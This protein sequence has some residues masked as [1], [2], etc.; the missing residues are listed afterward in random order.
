MRRAVRREKA[1]RGAITERDPRYAPTVGS[2][3][4]VEAD[5]VTRDRWSMALSHAGHSAIVVASLR[6]AL[7]AVGEGGIDVVV[8]DAHDSITGLVELAR[9]IDALPDAPP[10]VLVS[11]SPAAPEASVRM[12]AA[13][14]LPKPCEPSE[15]VAV[16]TRLL[17]EL[18]PVRLVDDD[19]SGPTRVFSER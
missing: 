17:G 7:P 11:G 19:P 2:I 8:I 16:V 13:S 5:V 4:L 14:F 9:A 6:E 15:L 1:T 12:G 18:R 10:I 3:L